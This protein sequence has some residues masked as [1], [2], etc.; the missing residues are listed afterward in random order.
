M[1]VLAVVEDKLKTLPGQFE[2][3]AAEVLIEQ[4]EIKYTNKVLVGVGLCVSFYDFL[5]IGDPYVYPAEGSSHQL[6]KFR[7]VVFRPFVGEVL[8]G[9]L[10]SSSRSGIHVSLGFF[11]DIVIPQNLLPQPSIYDVNKNIWSWR[12]CPNPE[13]EPDEF[14]DLALEV[15]EEVRFRVRTINFVTVTNTIKEKRTSVSS[16][17][18][19]GTGDGD[20][21]GGTRLRSSS[22]VG[23]SSS[24]SS[25]G[26]ADGGGDGAPPA[27]MQ[28]LGLM[29]EDGLGSLA[30]WG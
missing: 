11:E 16:E 22:S 23:L 8:T 3:D 15:G 2:G 10:T 7:I 14:N 30:W 18:R 25:S 21:G 12:H 28:I 20:E 6:V 26:G 24:A 19:A 29:N 9:K 17:S 27:P 13:E 5:D 1:Y 4:I